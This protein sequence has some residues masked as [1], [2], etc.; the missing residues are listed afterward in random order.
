MHFDLNFLLWD[1][2]ISHSM[3]SKRHISRYLL[4]CQQF[5]LWVFLCR[6]TSA[7]LTPPTRNLVHA[8]VSPVLEVTRSQRVEALQLFSQVGV[9]GWSLYLYLQGDISMY[10][11]VVYSHACTSHA[12]TCSSCSMHV[13]TCNSVGTR[14]HLVETSPPNLPSQQDGDSSC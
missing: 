1:A 13:R 12:C 4:L 5:P 9:G 6:S 2:H 10:M 11:H 7:M 14:H 8:L 3:Y